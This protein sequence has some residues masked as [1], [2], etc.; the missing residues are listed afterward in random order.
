MTC[1]NYPITK[2]VEYD[3]SSFGHPMDSPSIVR[4]CCII[5]CNCELGYLILY[6][7]IPWGIAIKVAL[8]QYPNYTIHIYNHCLNSA[9][10]Y[11]IWDL[12]NM[13]HTKPTVCQKTKSEIILL[14]LKDVMK[15][16]I[17]LLKYVII[18]IYTKRG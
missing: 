10:Q 8:K 11:L 13:S 5:L 7:Y 2:L 14:K 12:N 9:L 1:T 15:S 6:C 3:S 16:F 4:A 17:N 18:K